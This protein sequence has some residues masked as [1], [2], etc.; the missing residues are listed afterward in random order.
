MKKSLTERVS[1]HRPKLVLGEG[2]VPSAD[3]ISDGM[4]YFSTGA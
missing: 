3:T 4:M 2:E 1:N